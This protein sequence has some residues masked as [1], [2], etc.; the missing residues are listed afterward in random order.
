[1][2]K[3]TSLDELLLHINGKFVKKGIFI[4]KF[5]FTTDST[6][7]RTHRC[8]ERLGKL[9]KFLKLL[10]PSENFRKKN[11]VWLRPRSKYLS[12]KFGL[13]RGVIRRGDL[14]PKTWPK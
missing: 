6:G 7:D 12:E 5:F 9:S 11:L 1:M 4:S 2:A 10:I 8:L 13:M 14:E 3:F